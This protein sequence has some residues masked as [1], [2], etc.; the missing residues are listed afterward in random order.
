ME[1]KHASIAQVLAGRNGRQIA[2]ENDVGEIARQI[3]EIDPSLSLHFNEFGE[4]YVVVETL[5]SGKESRVTTVPHD[6]LD[7]RLLEELRRI[8][9]VKDFAAEIEEMDRRADREKDYRF[10]QKIGEAGERMAHAIRKDVQAK[11]KIIL[12]KGI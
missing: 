5:Q 8:S 3:K 12:P 2:V 4:Y 10:E 7:S 1:I 6:G 11:N 9:K